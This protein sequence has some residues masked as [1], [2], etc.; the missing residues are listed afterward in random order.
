MLQ[1]M[2]PSPARFVRLFTAEDAE[3]AEGSK[4][5][6]LVPHFA[7]E[8]IAELIK[9]VGGHPSHLA[10]PVRNGTEV[11]LRLE[12]SAASASLR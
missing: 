8:E 6:L 12:P 4:A 3:D 11:Y 5:G 2:P 10:S 7:Q 9:V 1:G